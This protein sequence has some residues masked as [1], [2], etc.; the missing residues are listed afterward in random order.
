MRGASQLGASGRV[1]SWEGTPHAA[2]VASELASI[3]VAFN[4]AVFA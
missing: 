1:V 4:L 2:N 3:N